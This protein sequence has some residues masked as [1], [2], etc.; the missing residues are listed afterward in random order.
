LID[1]ATVTDR[2]LMTIVLV[3]AAGADAAQTRT[4]PD[5]ETIAAATR[6]PRTSSEPSPKIRACQ[7]Q[8]EQ[9]VDCASVPE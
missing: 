8:R 5:R 2:S 6:R 3:A 4:S 7:G 9:A 1:G